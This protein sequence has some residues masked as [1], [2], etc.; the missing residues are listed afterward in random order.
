MVELMGPWS[1]PGSYADERGHEPIVWRIEPNE[2]RPGDGFEIRTVVRGIPVSGDDIDSLSPDPE[3][4]RAREV[5]PLDSLDDLTECTVGGEVPCTVEE[6]GVRRV[7]KIRFTLEVKEDP[8]FDDMHL[9][10]TIGDATYETDCD[11]F[12]SGLPRLAPLLPPG[13]SLICC[14]TCLYSDYSPHYGTKLG[15]NCHRD[16]KEQ[17]LTVKSK[18][19]HGVPITEEVP[20]TYLCSEYRQRIPG[21]GYRK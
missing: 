1:F 11:N 13:I 4:P 3:D 8:E 15:M 17:Y 16:A 18:E 12:E 2:R 7:E 9:C 20:E 10:L 19:V 21:I 5:L 6:N 14:F